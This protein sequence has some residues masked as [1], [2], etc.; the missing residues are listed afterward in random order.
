MQWQYVTQ[1]RAAFRTE[2][3]EAVFSWEG[4]T[5]RH[6]HPAAPDGFNA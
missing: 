6:G 4:L 2:A 1:P 5:S 3:A